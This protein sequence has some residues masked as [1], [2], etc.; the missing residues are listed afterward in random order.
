MTLTGGTRTIQVDTAQPTGTTGVWFLG[1]IGDGGNN[2]GLIKTG[3]SALVL[4]G[5]NTFTG[6]VTI[7]SGT[8][9]AQG[10]AAALGG[11]GTGLVTLGHTSGTASASL[12]GG[13]AT[14]FANAITVAAG[15]SGTATIGNNANAAA[16]FSGAVT[17][18][19]ALT[20]AST[21]T[22]SVTLSGAITGSSL[23]TVTGPRA[24]LSR[25]QETIPPSLVMWPSPPAPCASIPPR[26]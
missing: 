17:L 25:F 14:V 24:T 7:Q 1:A 26:R 15:S 11:S 19:K 4:G 21:G 23:L 6:G 10:N 16:A 5:A 12:L 9:I 13:D 2:Y 8:I 18:N 22:G 3:A 20:L